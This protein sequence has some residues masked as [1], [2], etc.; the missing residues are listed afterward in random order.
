MYIRLLTC[1]RVIVDHHSMSFEL[2]RH[3]PVAVCMSQA[4]LMLP[5]F[6]H[7]NLS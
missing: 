3:L 7:L 5:V 1:K 2:L 6:S 4:K